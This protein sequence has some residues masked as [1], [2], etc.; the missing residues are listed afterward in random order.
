MLVAVASVVVAAGLAVA[1]VVALV[2]A[3]GE[4]SEANA[5]RGEAFARFAE[6][7][8]DDLE[9]ARARDEVTEFARHA[10]A[11]MNTLDHRTLDE[12]LEA[13][14]EVTTGALREEVTS[15]GADQRRQLADARSVT[16]GQVLSVAVRELDVR[17]A[18][19]TVLAAVEVSVST[20]GTEATPR[21]QRVEASLSRTDQGWRLTALAKV[22]YVEPGS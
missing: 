11:V 21:Y 6:A 12:D 16:E 17:A 7:R 10:V 9:F 5:A 1:G 22:P 8:S 14:A 13:W 19:A 3:R 2:S 18:T 15:L 20:A 4:L